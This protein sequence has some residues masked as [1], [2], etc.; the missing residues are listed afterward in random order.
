[1]TKARFPLEGLIILISTLILC[2]AP[3][4]QV[5]VEIPNTPQLVQI[6]TAEPL[7][8][9]GY[10]LSIG[11]ARYRERIPEKGDIPILQRVV[12]G[13]F[14]KEKHLVSFE[15]RTYLIPVELR[16]GISDKLDLSIGITFSTSQGEKIVEDYYE[17]GEGEMKVARVYKQPIFDG[18][19]G[20]KY[21]IKPELG[22]GLPSLSIGGTFQMGYTADDRL[23]S[24]GYFLDDTPADGF[25]FFGVNLF[26]VATQRI[27]NLFKAH[28]GAGAYMCS[29]FQKTADSLMIYFFGGVEVAMTKELSVIADY[30]TKREING[31]EF[32]GGA[33]I[34]LKYS[35]GSPAL[36]AGFS[37]IP[38][39]AISI[40]SPGAAPERVKP[41]PPGETE[42]PLF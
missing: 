13:D 23:D 2:P 24:D 4:A 41:A 12:V 20:L 17:V 14:F 10:H 40:T 22:E 21:N 39:L 15:A 19:L 16:Y 11:M 9:G 8:K 3:F 18:R 33:S 28:A 25:P 35:F 5:E 42:A 30:I 32:S 37:T 7:G 1:M 31:I 26:M 29:K 36:N 38:G 34:G 27:K 6:P